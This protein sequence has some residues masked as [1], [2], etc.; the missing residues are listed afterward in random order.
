ML[1]FLLRK[2]IPFFPFKGTVLL[3]L[4]VY[5]SAGI[6]ISLWI[7]FCGLHQFLVDERQSDTED[8]EWTWFAVLL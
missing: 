1:F 5:G 2:N 8:G 7:R 3:L 4:I 6:H